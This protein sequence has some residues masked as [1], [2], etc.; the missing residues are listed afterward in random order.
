MTTAFPTTA[1]AAAAAATATATA[2]TTTTTTTTLPPRSIAV[3]A[4]ARGAGGQG[5]IPDR[6]TP[7]GV[8][9]GKFALLSLAL[10]INELGNRLG[11]SESV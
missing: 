4:S 6:V 3:R 9:S 5:S 7:E 10:C 11:G 8:K 2:T 1:A